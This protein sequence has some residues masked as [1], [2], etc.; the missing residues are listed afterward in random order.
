MEIFFFCLRIKRGNL[1][2][3]IE[4]VGHLNFSGVGRNR[5]IKKGTTNSVPKSVLSAD[6]Y[7]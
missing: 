1:E 4:H 5:P 3:H 7:L 6:S 2:L